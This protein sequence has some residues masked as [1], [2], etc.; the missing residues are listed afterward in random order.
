MKSRCWE[1]VCPTVPSST[2]STAMSPGLRRAKA[3][4]ELNDGV[5]T[6]GG[7]VWQPAR[8]ANRTRPKERMSMT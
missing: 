8:N 6:M 5:A 1:A 4:E 7:V 2:G 3:G